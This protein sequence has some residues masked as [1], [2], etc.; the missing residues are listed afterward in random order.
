MAAWQP[1]GAG[2]TAAPR[3]GRSQR[4]HGE[5]PRVWLSLCPYRAEVC[6][7]AIGDG[8]LEYIPP[9]RA[10][11]SGH[12]SA[13]R[14]VWGELGGYDSLVP[15]RSRALTQPRRL[16]GFGTGGGELTASGQAVCPSLRMPPGGAEVRRLPIPQRARWAALHRRDANDRPTP[17]FQSAT[18]CSGRVSKCPSPF[19]RWHFPLPPAAET[20]C[21]RAP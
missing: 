13:W 18:L 19:H 6:Q 17:V 16:R 2:Q 3:R 5:R 15:R 4:L 8:G 14:Q 11:I 10:P 9:P 20:T 1:G 7:S 21:L 12:L